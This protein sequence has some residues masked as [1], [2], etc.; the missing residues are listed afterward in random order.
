MLQVTI[1]VHE[2][3]C[4]SLRCYQPTSAKSTS[5]PSF[6]LCI[7]NPISQLQVSLTQSPRQISRILLPCHFCLCVEYFLGSL[8]WSLH[9][10]YLVPL[11]LACLAHLQYIGTYPFLWRVTSLGNNSR[12]LIILSFYLLKSWRLCCLSHL[13]IIHTLKSPMCMLVSST[14]SSLA[15]QPISRHLHVT[16][17]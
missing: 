6:H 8:A 4:N 9:W 2:G 15:N 17:K 10:R 13:R 7:I 3:K 1:H 16:P 5:W 14:S 11:T 12:K